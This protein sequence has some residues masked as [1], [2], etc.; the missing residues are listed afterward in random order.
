MH[1]V[2]HQLTLRQVANV[3]L[4][5]VGSDFV[6]YIRSARGGLASP[7]VLLHEQV[8]PQLCDGRVGHGVPR[9]PRSLLNKGWS[10]NKIRGVRPLIKNKK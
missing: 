3:A 2:F 9:D 5:P 8:C 1:K 7:A 10:F 6:A 4:G